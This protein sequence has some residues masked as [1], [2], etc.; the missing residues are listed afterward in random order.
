MNQT[1]R[2]CTNALTVVLLVAFTLSVGHTIYAAAAGLAAPDFTV[3]TPTTWVF[4][5]VA[6][7]S[8]ALARRTGRGVQLVLLTY[9]GVLLAISVFYYPTTFEPRQQ[10]TFGWLENDVYT[11][12]LMLAAY[13]GIE[14]LRGTSRGARGA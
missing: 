2:Q 1:I 5:A 10:T 4:Y 6:F 7:A 8:V 13:L 3:T 14:R 12:L 11:G 9:L